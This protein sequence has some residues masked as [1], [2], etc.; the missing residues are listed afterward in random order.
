MVGGRPAPL[1]DL[2]L[3]DGVL[4]ILSGV[5]ALGASS[6]PTSDGEFYGRRFATA[7]VCPANARFSPG[8]IEIG[9]RSG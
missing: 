4:R 6:L 3:T 7:A 1:E 5:Q 9:S 8:A 2:R